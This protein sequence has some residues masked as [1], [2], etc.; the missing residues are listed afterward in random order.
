MKL[1]AGPVFSAVLIGGG[2]GYMVFKK[3]GNPLY[4]IGTAVAI[5]A[6]EYLFLIWS[7]SLRNKK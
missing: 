1:E 4:G 5:C 3:T 2:I 7:N 6:G